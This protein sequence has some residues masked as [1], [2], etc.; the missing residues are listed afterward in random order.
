MKLEVR[1]VTE[2]EGDDGEKHK[3]MVLEYD[4]AFRDW[5]CG[6]EGWERLTQKRL[7]GLINHS[8]QAVMEDWLEYKK[9]I[10]SEIN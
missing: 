6:S 3:V 5:I 2:I 4:R 9:E 8:I 10:G 7:Q 1:A